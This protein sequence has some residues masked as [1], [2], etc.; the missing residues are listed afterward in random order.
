MRP[1]LLGIIALA[2][3][4]IAVLVWASRPDAPAAP[5]RTDGDRAAEPAAAALDGTAPT[6]AAPDGGQEAPPAAAA[7][8]TVAKTTA[9]DPI[10]AGSSAKG[11]ITVAARD[12]D[13]AP[14]L[15][16]PVG[17]RVDGD[18]FSRL[19]WRAATKAP[20]GTARVD[21]P[22]A[23]FGPTET[24]AVAMF[25]FPVAD[26]PKVAVDVT[27]P[28]EEA[29]A[30]TL[31]PIGEVE[32]I[33]DEVDPEIADEVSVTLG[34]VGVRGYGTAFVPSVTQIT[35]DAR[36]VFHWVGVGTQLAVSATRPGQSTPVE[37]ETPGPQFAGHRLQVRLSMK[38]R[39]GTPILVLQL[40]DARDEPLASTDIRVAMTA[41]AQS[42]SSSSTFTVRSDADGKIRLPVAD[43]MGDLA[44]R[45]LDLRA[46]PTE[47]SARVDVPK[48]LHPGDNDLGVVRLGEMPLLCA[49]VVRSD[50]T[51]EPIADARLIVLRNAPDGQSWRREVLQGR[52]KPDGTF[53]LR[54]DG[55]GPG[56]LSLSVSAPDYLEADPI[57]FVMGTGGL[58]IQLT[59]GARLRGSVLLGEVIEPQDVQVELWRDGR[60][61]DGTRLERRGDVG[62][63]GFMSLRPG[64]VSV[65]VRLVGD[66]DGGEPIEGIDLRAGVTNEDPR[67]QRIDLADGRRV[68]R[69]ALVDEVGTPVRDARVAVL[70]GTDQEH[71]EGYLLP[72]GQARIVTAAASLNVMAFAKGHR[73]VEVRGVRE[74]Q[75]VIVPRALTVR[76]RL[77]ESCPVPKDPYQLQAQLFRLE[78]GRGVRSDYRW[79][80]YQGTSGSYS[81][82]GSPPWLGVEAVACNAAG[83]AEIAVPRPG[84][85]GIH[86]S[87]IKRAGSS[88]V[89]TGVGS[90]TKSIQV[91]DTASDQAW[92]AGPAAAAIAAAKEQ[93]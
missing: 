79:A 74:G 91:L 65:R 78:Q 68:V 92:V 82:S 77:P 12:A 2:L 38:P 3:G 4:G 49:G 61:D 44:H 48:T 85:Y 34:A 47:A 46:E 29:V 28:P 7:G 24:Q 21:D 80:L 26:G 20:D 75:R 23:V 16:A 88:T 1:L 90:E 71:F 89:A 5:V 10:T 30:L 53:E 59:P 64:A 56:K 60:R 43:A 33:L 62:E 36:T 22:S 54:G 27:A 69:F 32:V 19:R 86:W 25:G 45:E 37:I 67:L 50:A 55:T 58:E 87:L 8:R 76:L 57:P 40:N 70:N 17:L 72:R 39:D 52:T 31:P 83:E 15:G 63:F 42:G 84:H 51:T 93:L 11:A 66:V 73:S 18:A 14:V 35:N 81:G 41:L 6:A 9:L 13:G